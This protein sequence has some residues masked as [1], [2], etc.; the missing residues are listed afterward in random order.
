MIV[1]IDDEFYNSNKQ[2]ILLILGDT[3]KEHL[4]NMG[5]KKK[6]CSFPE[7][8]D[9]DKAKEFMKVPEYILKND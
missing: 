9:I 6:Y 2:P 4:S 5:N 3:E 1:K 7:E 8:Y